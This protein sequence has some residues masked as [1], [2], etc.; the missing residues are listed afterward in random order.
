MTR[1]PTEMELRCALAFAVEDGLV[2]T[3]T[4]DEYK[5]YALGRVWAVIRAMRVPTAGMLAATKNSMQRV[6][7]CIRIADVHGFRLK[8]ADEHPPMYH[9]W[10]NMID[11]A[12]PPEGT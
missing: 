6:D 2:W 5:R 3:Q 12:S 11:S 8:W 1:E 7:D 9:A 4:T 10:Q